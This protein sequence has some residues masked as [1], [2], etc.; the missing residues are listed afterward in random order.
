M[1]LYV[2]HRD[3]EQLEAQVRSA[4]DSGGHS[5]L[6][7]LGYG[8]G[9]VVLNLET[10]R[11]GLACKR[12][13]TLPNRQRFELYQQSLYDYL[14][15]LADKGL[16]VAD[17]EVWHQ[18]LPSGKVVAYCVQDALPSGHL[19]STLLHTE[20]ESWARDFF[21]RFLDLVE[22]VVTPT[23]GLDAQASNWMDLGGELVYLDVTTPL[24]RDDHGRE[25]LDVRLF[26]SSLPWILRAPV[27]L[28]MTR[29]MLEKYYSV[30]GVILDFLGNLHKEGL[31]ELVPALLSQANARLKV[32][33]SY[34]EAAAYYARDARTWE[35]IQ[36]L[37]RADRLWQLRVRRRPYCF[38]LPPD[39]R[40]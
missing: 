36:R 40:R 28:T 30:R 14:R 11:G 6:G 35:S 7:V 1:P 29:A 18:V 2:P 34:R 15:C 32:P 23:L 19:C 39:V 31:A 37:R 13:P 25:R 26:V 4:F 16:R 17:T 20:D 33:I 22:R 21:G 3:L 27:R 24:M 10:D 8:E 12:L 9:S 5:S 38:L